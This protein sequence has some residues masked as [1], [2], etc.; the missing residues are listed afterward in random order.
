MDSCNSCLLGYNNSIAQA[1]ASI[2]S[3][4]PHHKVCSTLQNGRKRLESD[5]VEIHV[6]SAM[7]EQRPE[8]DDVGHMRVVPDLIAEDAPHTHTH[9][10]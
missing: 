2:L 9:S 3:L 1:N 10:T 7:S 8:A 6:H 4:L 5:H